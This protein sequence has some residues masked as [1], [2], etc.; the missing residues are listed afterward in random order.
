[1]LLVNYRPWN[2]L[3]VTGSSLK[4][5]GQKLSVLNLF[6]T[7]DGDVDTDAAGTTFMCAKNAVPKGV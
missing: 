4:W 1:M 3:Q 6:M 7:I 2:L 5:K